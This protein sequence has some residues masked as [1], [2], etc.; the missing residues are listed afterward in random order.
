MH[1]LPL[2]TYKIV[3]GKLNVK[4]GETHFLPYILL[5]FFKSF[6]HVPVCFKQIIRQVTLLKTSTLYR[7]NGKG[8]ERVLFKE[9]SF[10]CKLKK[11]WRMVAGNV[12]ILYT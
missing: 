6:G 1:R 10:F 8:G 11:F 9:Y 3:T 7:C 4:D 12:N 2:E 5:S